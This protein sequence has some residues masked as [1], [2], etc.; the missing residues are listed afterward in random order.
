M[1]AARRNTRIR[2]R[3]LRSM[4]LSSVLLAAAHRQNGQ[5]WRAS[6]HDAVSGNGVA[7]AGRRGY[8]M[9]A[10]AAELTPPKRPWNRPFAN[11]PERL[12]QQ[13]RLEKGRGRLISLSRRTGGGRDRD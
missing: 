8:S 7:I 3:S 11:I 6:I 4:S 12:T 1:P 5:T 13:N 10:R 9:L 2:L